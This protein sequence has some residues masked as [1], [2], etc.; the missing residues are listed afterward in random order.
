MEKPT[1]HADVFNKLVKDDS[2]LIGYIAYSLYKRQKIEYLQNKA[3]QGIPV[4]EDMR[5]DFSAFACTSSQIGLLRH[6]AEN[7]LMETVG[8]IASEEMEQKEQEMLSN[9]KKDIR[10]IAEDVLRKRVP[11]PA[12]TIGLNVASALIFS[13]LLGIIVF[14]FNTSEK[15]TLEKTNDLLDKVEQKISAPTLA[16]SD[17]IKTVPNYT[18]ESE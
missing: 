3:E 6:Q 17:S 13:L 12:G 8:N 1:K 11:S 4:T 16:S 15:A 14:L 5:K 18:K 2:D 7:L 9:Y 10:E